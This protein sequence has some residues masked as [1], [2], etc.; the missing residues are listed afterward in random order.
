MSG[1]VRIGPFG[2]LGSP[3]GP[4]VIPMWV[5]WLSD[6]NTEKTNGVSAT[7]VFL[8]VR[9]MSGYLT[10]QV[11]GGTPIFRAVPSKSPQNII[12]ISSC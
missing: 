10:F 5:K 6:H 11:S 4:F 2:R 9:M 12:P 3:E 8:H 7:F 1:Y